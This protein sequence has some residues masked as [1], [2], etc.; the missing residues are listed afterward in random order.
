[1]DAG[2]RG[3]GN[4]KCR[5]QMAQSARRTRFFFRANDSCPIARQTRT[6][7]ERNVIHLRYAIAS[8]FITPPVPNLTLR[9]RLRHFQGHSVYAPKQRIA[10]GT[11]FAGYLR[12]VNLTNLRTGILGA[13][14]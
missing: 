3:S 4:R 2:S 13:V 7:R 1:M 10:R 11:W 14:A 9:K 12:N 5:I 8:Q 6:R